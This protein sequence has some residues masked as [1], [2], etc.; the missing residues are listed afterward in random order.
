MSCSDPRL[1]YLNTYGYN[2]VKLPRAGIDPLQVIGRDG[3]S[4][5]DLGSLSTIWKSAQPAPKPEGPNIAANINGSKTDSLKLSIGLDILSGILQGMGAVNPKVD[6]AFTHARTVQF[7]FADV[8][9][10]LVTPVEVGS[11]LSAG[12]L[13]TTS[14][15]AS[16]F[17]SPDK[18]AFVVTSVLKSDS[19]IVS[20]QQNSGTSLSASVPNIQQVV[21]ADVSVSASGT[22][23]DDVTFKG[24]QPITFGFKMFGIA[25]RDGHW[26][27]FGQP[28]SSSGALARSAPAPLMGQFEEHP[29]LVSPGALISELKRKH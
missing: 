25:Y 13:D 12:D 9:E 4:I 19:I 2:V 17:L 6:A 7:T 26:Q 20:T 27:V 5:D 1:T 24:P 18:H 14:P 23:N 15:F 3:S 11:Y 8:T 28:P 10:T 22:A 21:G 16:Y 29:I